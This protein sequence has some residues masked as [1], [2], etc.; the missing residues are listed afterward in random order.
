MAASHSSVSSR[1][2]YLIAAIVL[3]QLADAVST[4]IA[5]STGVSESNALVSALGLWTTK[6]LVI[7][8]L[9]LFGRLLSCRALRAVA[10]VYCLIVMWNLHFAYSVA[11]V[12]SLSIIGVGF[13]AGLGFLLS[14]RTQL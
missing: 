12:L 6:L 11:A 5:I 4:R 7:S 3:L 8:V 9:L 13:V 1:K 2:P 14:P 10:V